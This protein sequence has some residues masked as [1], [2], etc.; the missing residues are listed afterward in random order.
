MKKIFCLVIVFCLFALSVR[1]DD[2]V[3]GKWVDNVVTQTKETWNS[4]HYDIYVPMY[5]W[6]NR[7]TY[8][9]EHIAKYNE[10]AFGFGMGKS[11]YDDHGNWHGLYA[12]FFKDSNYYWETIAGYAYQKNW[13][14]G[15][16]NDW[17]VGLGYTL[18]LTQRHEYAYIPVP[19]PLPIFGIE[20]KRLAVQGAYVP[21]WENMGNVAFFWIRFNLD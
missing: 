13:R 16:D 11:M 18:S 15:C 2:G 7:L 19:L 20:Y 4:P 6:H 14:I 12:M 5:A 3:I 8:D 1:A 17:R 9:D 21:G 10:N